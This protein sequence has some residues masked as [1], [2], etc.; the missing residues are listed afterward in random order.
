MQLIIKNLYS[1]VP[2][3]SYFQSYARLPHIKTLFLGFFSDVFSW[4]FGICWGVFSFSITFIF[5]SKIFNFSVDRNNFFK[6][7]L[8]KSKLAMILYLVYRYSLFRKYNYIMAEVFKLILNVLTAP[9]LHAYKY[10]VLSFVTA[11]MAKVDCQRTNEQTKKPLWF[12][13]WEFIFFFF[14]VI[15]SL[16]IAF[17]KYRKK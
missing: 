17:E 2:L 3:S 14:F 16:F 4:F 12:T 7:T 15:S 10:Y 11:E 6:N 13:S 1:N 5:C 8:K 9:R